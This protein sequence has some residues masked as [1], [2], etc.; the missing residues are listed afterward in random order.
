MT[1]YTCTNF[2]LNKFFDIEKYYEIVHRRSLLNILKYYGIRYSTLYII[3]DY[4]NENYF[5]IEHCGYY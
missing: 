4:S 1:Y 2:E 3:K 5:V